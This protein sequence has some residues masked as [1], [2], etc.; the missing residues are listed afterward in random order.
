MGESGEK[1]V[2]IGFSSCHARV[3]DPDGICDEDGCA[4]GKGTGD[5]GFDGCELFRSAGGADGG[6][7]E[8]G[9]GPFVPFWC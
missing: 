7:L 5:H 1:V 8:E 2:C 3:D 6:A 4:A 9:T